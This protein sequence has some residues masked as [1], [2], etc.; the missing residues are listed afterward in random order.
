LISL[1][2]KRVVNRNFWILFY[3]VI[4]IFVIWEKNIL[5]T[6]VIIT[7]TWICHSIKNKCSSTSKNKSFKLRLKS[8]RLWTYRKMSSFFNWIFL[9]INW[10][11]HGTSSYCVA[12]MFMIFSA[13]WPRKVKNSIFN[14]VCTRYICWFSKTIL[15]QYDIKKINF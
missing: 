3:M 8:I 4:F 11:W 14:K 5:D 15:M 7:F 6:D 9:T 12:T 10:S 2:S 13:S 1:T